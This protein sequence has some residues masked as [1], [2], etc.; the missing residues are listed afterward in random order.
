MAVGCAG[1]AVV[2]V[3]FGLYGLISYSVGRRRAELGIRIAVGAG[4]ANIVQL[5]LM[6]GLRLAAIGIA[7]GLALTLATSRGLESQLYQVERFDPLTV[8]ASA[9]L[10]LAVALAASLGPARRASKADPLVALREQ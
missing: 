6:Q 7:V 8:A 10:V 3:T 5:V 1:L 9:L 2:F 4:R